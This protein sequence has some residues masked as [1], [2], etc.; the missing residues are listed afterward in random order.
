ML[1]WKKKNPNKKKEF[2]LEENS[3]LVYNKNE[4]DKMNGIII[5]QEKKEILIKGTKEDLLDLANTIT[6][7]ANSKEKQDHIHID[8]YTLLDNNSE[9]KELIIEKEG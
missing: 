1:K 5:K 2:F 4:D 9:I 6:T 3:F 7:I 8:K